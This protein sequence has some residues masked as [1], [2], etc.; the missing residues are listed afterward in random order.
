M[1][2]I[3]QERFVGGLSDGVKKAY[4]TLWKKVETY[5]YE[6]GKQFEDFTKEDFNEF[7]KCKLIKSSAK[8]TN[9]K[10]NL[11]KK[12]ANFIG[13][14]FVQLDFEA[15]RIMVEDYLKDKKIE[16]ENELRYVS[17]DELSVASNRMANDIDV[18]IIYLLRYGVSGKN[19]TELVNLK[20]K[21]IDMENKVIKL[22]DR[23]VKIDDTM[24]GILQFAMNQSE[25]YVIKDL[26]KDEPNCES[27]ELNMESEYLI[28]PKPRSDND[29]GLSSYKASGMIG[30]LFRITQELGLNISA[31]NLL[32]SHA[33][34]EVIKYEKE[35]GKEL[36]MNE[37]AKYLKQIGSRQS[38]DDIVYM[39]KWVK[40]KYGK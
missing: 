29:F 5:E 8:S 28:K 3:D 10:V 4:M 16:D 36:S 27:Y 17:M 30:R 1:N 39:A 37:C 19:F 35:I 25:Y 14:D 38:G 9:V 15:V 20:T 18:A 24:C 13:C 21:N 6:I 11:L 31:I 33:V 40:K 12:Y 26:D 23:M 34:D 7:V 2:K 22:K 32:Q